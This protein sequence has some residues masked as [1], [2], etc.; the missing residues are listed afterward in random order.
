M[1]ARRD[2]PQ[3]P[4]RLRLAWR[5]ERW[6]AGLRS[7]IRAALPPD[8]R[9]APVLVALVMGDQQGIAPA[10]WQLFTRTGIGHLIS[11]SGL[12]ITMIA[13]LAGAAV[14]GLWRRSFGMGRRL[15]RPLPL[16]LPAGHVA[17]LAAVLAATGYG[18]IAGM[19]VP[20]LR[21]VAMLT[22]AVLA[23]WS[24]RSP[25][26]SLVLA[27]AAFVA[28]AID[29]WAVLSAGFWLS[30]GAVGVIFLAARRQEE[31]G[32]SDAGGSVWARLRR[33]LADA[34]RTQWAVTVGLVPL[35]L[36]LFQQVSVI[37][38]LANA[39]AIPVVSLLVT[40]LALLGAV[41]P[42]SLAAVLLGVAHWLM[43]W[44]AALL[45][46]MAGAPWAVWQAA[47]SG[48]LAWS[49]AVAGTAILLLPTAFG[50]RPRLHGLLL[51][52]PMLLAS[53][54]PVARGEF[55]AVALDVGQGSAVLV[56]TRSH[57]L[58]YDA[59]PA[60]PS[61][62]SAGAQVIVPYLRVVGVDRLQQM[63][64]THEDADHAGGARDVG[65]AVPVTEHLAGAPLGHPLLQAD[66]MPAWK[67]CVAGQRW[68]WDGV[69]FA[70]LHPPAAWAQDAAMP[71]N[72][73]SCVLRVA[74]AHRTLLLTGDIRAEDE[75]RMVAEY[76]E[77]NL[78]ADFL[79]VPHH[80]SGT[81][82]SL[83]LLRA[84]R[85]EVAVFQ[86]GHA[87][88][89]R[90]PRRDVWERYGREGVLR[91]RTDETGAVTM[92]TSGSDYTVVSY[93]QQARRYWRDS[94][95]APQ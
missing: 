72:A 87:N 12:H 67:P 17:R 68:E 70:V 76:G 81:S 75:S 86:L 5:I 69:R 80:G 38:P 63:M 48:P 65:A 25:P 64:I 32:T 88:R 85:P 54:E 51:T 35:T 41:A 58:L 23:A 49:L 22:V 66:P 34:A 93:R 50:L 89:Y 71:S 21:T 84:V 11:I 91:Y 56:E 2:G 4:A 33:T 26:P 83:A 74:T 94:P 37:S 30:F 73:R 40:P 53:R 13:G 59:G 60:Y 82:S 28:M 9:F 61:G 3:A 14:H 43:V 52:L 15:R 39:V 16:W 29:P 27:W 6:R 18:L 92:A 90:H 24:G 1:R 62:S 57:V 45:G 47:W 31:G 7:H 10:D 20:A 19:Q 44:L 42:L 77:A 55:R 78:R 46:W 79:L 95:V 8:A 36:L